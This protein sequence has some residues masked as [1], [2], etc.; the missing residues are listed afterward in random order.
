[1]RVLAIAR[2]WG[3]LSRVLTTER[4][5]HRIITAP[6][7]M[8][9]T[10]P[11]ANTA[12]TASNRNQHVE[13]AP[14][15]LQYSQP[16]TPRCVLLF[17]TLGDEWTF[18]PYDVDVVY[19][20]VMSESPNSPDRI[21]VEEMCSLLKTCVGLSIPNPV[22]EMAERRVG[23]MYHPS[24]SDVLLCLMACH[25]EL[26]Q[27]GETPGDIQSM[28]VRLHSPTEINRTFIMVREIRARTEATM[29]H[30]GTSFKTTLTR[31]KNHAKS[32]I[33]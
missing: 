10:I 3:S 11:E 8:N 1:M 6:N 24:D 29:K 30:F 23:T 17:D 21:T 19:Q 22:I 27:E 31:S 16:D 25:A 28:T 4:N 9:K 18:L 7:H 5:L 13:T 12:T 15:S 32:L 20:R 26:I 33:N 2:T 14:Q